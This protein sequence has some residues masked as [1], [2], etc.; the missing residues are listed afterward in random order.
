MPEVTL[1]Q[2]EAARFRGAPLVDVREPDEYQAAHV[3][4]AVLIPLGQIVER[5]DEVDGDEPVYVIC[6]M[7]SRSAKAVQWLRTQGIDARNVAGGTK[8]WMESGKPIAIGPFP[9]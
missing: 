5:V 2:L 9:G 4:G 8:A 1:D 6:Q 3:P 7:G